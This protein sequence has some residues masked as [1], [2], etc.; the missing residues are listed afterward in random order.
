MERQRRRCSLDVDAFGTV[1]EGKFFFLLSCNPN[2]SP[3]SLTSL[4]VSLRGLRGR[5]AA[6][7]E[8]SVERRLRQ[9]ADE[10]AERRAALLLFGS[11]GCELGEIFE[12]VL[13]RR[14]DN[15]SRGLFIDFDF[16]LVDDSRR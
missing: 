10:P 16:D 14:D 13:W 6:L 4:L 12:G 3:S 11:G 5:L 15:G 9:G 2:F 1:E 8:G 7:R